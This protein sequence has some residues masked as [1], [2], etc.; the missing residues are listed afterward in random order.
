METK[1]LNLKLEST[2]FTVFELSDTEIGLTN[3]SELKDLIEQ[4]IG[5]GN[6]NIAVDL[7]NVMVINSSGLGIL[8]G[9]MK[10]VQN[11]KG[12]FKILNPQDKIMSLFKITKL[13][14]V[15]DIIKI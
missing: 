14:L 5:S 3:L 7:R 1:K 12:L 2:D 6:I 10:R 11:A 15:F 9:C 4:E 13:N 8:I